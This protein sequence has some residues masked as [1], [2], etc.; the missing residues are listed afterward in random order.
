VVAATAPTACR[1]RGNDAVNVVDRAATSSPARLLHGAMLLASLR[2][3]TVY[4]L[5]APPGST[6][7]VY[8]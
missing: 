4:L 1:K 5:N 8:T 3:A 6:I 7:A 2:D